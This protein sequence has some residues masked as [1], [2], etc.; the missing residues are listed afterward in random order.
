MNGVDG[1]TGQRLLRVPDQARLAAL[2][3]GERPDPKLLRWLKRVWLRLSQPHYGLPFD[4]DP[5]NLAQSGWAIVYH[6]AEEEPIRQAL[7]RLV[8]H[9]GSQVP[10]RHFKVLD[11]RPGESWREWLARHGSEPGSVRPQKVP[12]YVLLIGPPERIPFEFQH[13]L[14]I[15]H[16]VGR[17]SF[18]GPDGY[19][20]YGESLIDYES[21]AYVPCGKDAAFFAPCHEGD[22]ATQLSADRLAAP[23]A[24]SVRAGFRVRKLLRET[25]TRSNLN[26]IFR[27]NGGEGPPALLFSASHGLG[28]PRGHPEQ[29]ACQGALLC[30]DWSGL[31]SLRR[32]HYFAAA[33]LDPEA[34]VHGLIAFL[35]AC[36]GAGTPHR[37][38]FDD[39]ARASSELADQPFV[40]RLPQALLSHPR[41]G[42]L[43]VIGHLDRAW[44]YSILGLSGMPQ[45]LPFENALTGLLGGWPV[46]HSMRTFRERYV[47]L[48]AAL[49]DMLVK[50]S[51]RGTVS[52]E[53]L[54]QTWMERNDAR[55][56]AVLGDPASRLRVEA[57]R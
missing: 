15:E 55:N 17:I 18:D 9:R 12:Y 19:V 39:P 32:D 54:T 8:E 43:A 44:G 47:A 56:Y 33:D 6:T 2:I 21:S 1:A 52:D 46:G 38:D 37:D 40:A 36:F 22:P 10:Q 27:G 31:G 50:I 25:A 23:L 24:G 3:R 51:H 41:G 7:A 53:E 14:S 5:L 11:Y 28:W 4:T 13:H 26:D 30:Q 16:A 57:M 45:L 29:T 20:H 34:R 35:F 49:A 48:S 42:A